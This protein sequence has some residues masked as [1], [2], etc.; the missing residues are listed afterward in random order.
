MV[1]LRVVRLQRY[2]FDEWVL[3]L[4]KDCSMKY[5]IKIKIKKKSGTKDLRYR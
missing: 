4:L 3:F 1:T 5:G 2:G